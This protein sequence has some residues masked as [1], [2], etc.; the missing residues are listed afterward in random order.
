MELNGQ[1]PELNILVN[2]I[3]E[4]KVKPDGPG[5]QRR[6]LSALRDDQERLRLACWFD[7]HAAW[8][9]CMCT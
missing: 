5:T 6:F 7:M 9:L 3:S 2:G 4:P 8:H 1:K